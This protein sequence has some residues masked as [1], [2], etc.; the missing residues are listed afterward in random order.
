MIKKDNYE[1]YANCIQMEQMAAPEIAE[2]FEDG[3]FRKWYRN[4][5][6]IRTDNQ[7]DTSQEEWIKG[8]NKR[9]TKKERCPHN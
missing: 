4:E 6:N 7:S 3:K 1:K 2:L 8:Y 9:Q 5:Y